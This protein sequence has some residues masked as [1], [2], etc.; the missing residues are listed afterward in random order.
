MAHHDNRT[1]QMGAWVVI[2]AD[3]YELSGGSGSVWYCAIN[4]D[5]VVQ[6]TPDDRQRCP[7]ASRGRYALTPG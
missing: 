6:A 7:Q 3:W 4:G 1:P 2:N 5:P